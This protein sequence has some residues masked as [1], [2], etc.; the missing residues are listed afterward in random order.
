MVGAGTLH[1]PSDTSS[2][3][4]E[5]VLFKAGA[6]EEI[7][8]DGSTNLTSSEMATFLRTCVGQVATLRRTIS[9]PTAGQK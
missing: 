6:P 1:F 3:K 5:E 2:N 8:M 4:A 7:S 9:N